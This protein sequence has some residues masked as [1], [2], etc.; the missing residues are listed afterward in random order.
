M[1]AAGHAA[2]AGTAPPLAVCYLSAPQRPSALTIDPP[3]VRVIQEKTDHGR[4]PTQ[5]RSSR[6]A[7]LPAHARARGGAG[8]KAWV[9]RL[10]DGPRAPAPQ[11]PAV[12]VRCP[13]ATPGGMSGAYAA[14]SRDRGLQSM[15][16]GLPSHRQSL[17]PE[18]AEPAG[19]TAAVDQKLLQGAAPW[20]RAVTSISMR[21]RGS[22]SP[23]IIIVAAGEAA[24]KARRKAG[25][26]GSKSARSGRT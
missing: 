3:P 26:Q 16:L 14:A 4:A 6:R 8:C 23:A 2:R 13:R 18:P 12:C 11:A 24:P 7:H 22:S 17:G 10:A 15:P 5:Q 25:Q 1:G 9:A 20:R 21:M 19:P